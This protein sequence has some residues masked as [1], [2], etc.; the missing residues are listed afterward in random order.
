MSP[1]SKWQAHRRLAGRGIGDDRG[2]FTQRFELTS[3]MSPARALTGVSEA[4]KLD[5]DSLD[6]V[7]LIYAQLLEEELDPKGR[8]KRSLNLRA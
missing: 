3:Q 7:D 1:A 2:I 6:T 8:N 5:A 4:N